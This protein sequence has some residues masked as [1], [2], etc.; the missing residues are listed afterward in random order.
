M[1]A[2]GSHPESNYQP[3]GRKVA[4]YE[5]AA[6]TAS[7]ADYVAAIWRRRLIVGA[8]LVLGAVIGA[9]V[10]P[11]FASSQRSYIATQR[12]DI[13][14]FG[15]EKAPSSSTTAKGTASSG[16]ARY[17]DPTVMAAVLAKVGADAGKLDATAGVQTTNRAAAALGRLSAKSVA[18]TTWVDMSFTDSSARLAS[19]ILTG[20]VGEYV[21][22]RNAA[23]DSGLKSQVKVLQAQ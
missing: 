23:A 19:K 12:L 20:Y 7:L 14:A 17:A 4:R 10:L 9:F 21:A 6:Q 2:Y 11:T 5:S 22:K 15:T 1:P 8:A 16:D 13:R 18:G 3:G